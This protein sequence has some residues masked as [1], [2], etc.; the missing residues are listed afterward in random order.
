MVNSIGRSTRRSAGWD[1]K[2]GRL[3]QKIDGVD[4]K[5]DDA[6][7]LM[8]E[9]FEESKRFMRMLTEELRGEIHLLADKIVSVDEK[10]DRRVTRLEKH[11]G[12]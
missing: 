11:A 12:F 2:F 7:V 1:Q 3:D 10:F 8:G 4:R 5:V 6:V 9:K